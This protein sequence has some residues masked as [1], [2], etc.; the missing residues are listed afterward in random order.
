MSKLRELRKR[1]A[2]KIVTYY[3]GKQFDKAVEKAD[4]RHKNGEGKIYVVEHF[5]K[6]KLLSTI[7]RAQ[8]RLIKH[9]AQKLHKNKAYYS[10]EYGM[11]MLTKQCWYYTA[12]KS[13]MGAISEQ[14]KIIR[15]AAFIR[16]GLKKA[17]LL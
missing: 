5:E 9:A 13:E 17:R 3:Y 7:D 2:G 11:K 1:L 16:S 12:D 10:P 4:K 6:G 8:F 15:R 14:Q